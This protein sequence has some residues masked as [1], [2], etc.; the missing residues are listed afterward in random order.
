MARRSRSR[1]RRHS[2]SKENPRSYG[3]LR[4]QSGESGFQSNT[5]AQ[6]RIEPAKEEQAPQPAPSPSGKDRA[7]W[8]V[9]YGR[10]FSD[11]KQLLVVSVGLFVL[12]LIV[13]LFL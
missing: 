13:G 4:T 2:P 7:D 6:T 10:V 5:P 1:R 9:E 8:N 11:L 3:E 12:M